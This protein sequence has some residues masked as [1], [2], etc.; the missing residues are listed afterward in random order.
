MCYICYVLK[1]HLSLHWDN[2]NISDIFLRSHEKYSVQLSSAARLLKLRSSTVSCYVM[3]SIYGAQKVTK[4]IFP[5]KVLKDFC[6]SFS[7]WPVII[8]KNYHMEN[9]AWMIYTFL[10]SKLQDNKLEN[11]WLFVPWYY[12]PTFAYILTPTSLILNKMLKKYVLKYL[13]CA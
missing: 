6:F 3:K 13:N 2:K 4:L 1:L 11:E 5:S 12:L 7:L 8:M 9:L 10:F